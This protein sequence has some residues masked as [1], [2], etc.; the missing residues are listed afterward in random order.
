MIVTWFGAASTAGRGSPNNNMLAGINANTGELLWSQVLP[1]ENTIN[2]NT[3]I[4]S[5]GKIFATTGY[6]GGSWLLELKDNG[7]KVDV[8]WKND[9]DNQMGGAVKVGNYVY[10]TGHQ[11]RAFFCI[12]WNTG[13]IKYRES[14]I[15]GSATIYA[16]GLLYVY[17]DRGTMNLIKPNPDRFELVSSFPIT[18]G[19]AEHWAHP[20][21]YEGVLY[22]RHGNALMA[23]KIK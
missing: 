7:K 19:T 2:P 5:N 11:N 9:A 22:I 3:P 4:Y 15:S 20:V 13:A 1:S 6:R 16:D 21:I 12:D 14:S 8:L 18:L 23:Y 10:T 17:T